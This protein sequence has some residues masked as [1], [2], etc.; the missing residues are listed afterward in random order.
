M[1]TSANLEQLRSSAKDLLHGSTKPRLVLLDRRN[2][3][4]Q[5]VSMFTFTER[6]S[7]RNIGNSLNELLHESKRDALVRLNRTPR[8]QKTARLDVPVQQDFK[9]TFAVS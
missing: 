9:H 1:C 5:R 8:E 6:A 2:V 3:F 7:N 4:L